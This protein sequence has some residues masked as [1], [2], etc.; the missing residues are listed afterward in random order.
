[1][2]QDVK[3]DPHKVAASFRAQDAL[4]TV[5]QARA[6][7]LTAAQVQGFLQR[8][9]WERLYRGVYRAAGAPRTDRQRVRAACLAA[10]GAAIASHTS[11]AWMLGL[12]D[13]APTRPEITVS[14]DWAPSLKGVRVH[15]SRDLDRARTVI[16]DGIPT[17]NAPRTLVDLGAVMAPGPLTDVFDRCLALRLATLQSVAAELSR[18]SRKGRR[19]TA[20]LRGM[21]SERDLLAAPYPS[22]LESR[23]FRLF[24]HY[25]LPAPEVEMTAGPNGEY[26]LDFAYPPI[27]LAI[28][29]DGYV[30][31]CTPEQQRRDNRRRNRLFVAGWHVLVF[32][33]ED[34][35]EHPA[36]VAA[37]IQTARARLGAA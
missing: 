3:A 2:K 13:R 10:G 29:V 36:D 27:K 19:G 23:M 15:R 35:T 6:L 9:E 31:H 21:I 17:T 30:W 12:V 16:R 5:A 33:W 1:M 25:R 8:G 24:H 4:I 18:V 34:V 7:G 20:S 14:T 22:V 32:T 37:E 26:R 11:A 28:E